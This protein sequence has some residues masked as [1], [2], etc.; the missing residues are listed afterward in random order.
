M[1]PGRGR[2]RR[3]D[4]RLRPRHGVVT[5][6]SRR[7]RRSFAGTTA[8]RQALRNGRRPER[9]D[10]DEPASWRNGTANY[11]FRTAL[12][13]HTANSL[14]ADFPE[15]GGVH[16]SQALLLTGRGNAAIA[17][18]DVRD[19]AAVILRVLVEADHEGEIYELA[20]PEPFTFGEAAET[21]SA[22]AGGPI[23][24]RPVSPSST[25]HNF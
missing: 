10:P 17:Q 6:R 24:Y 16:P 3:A 11:R 9:P 19:I 15:D 25:R 18:V 7:C 2:S 20:G 23:T 1:P 4:L 21:L 8:H 12:D 13:F 5:R 22:V 14:H